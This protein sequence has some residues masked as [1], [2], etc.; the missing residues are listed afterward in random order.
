[1]SAVFYH[2]EEQ[3]RL[4]EAAKAKHALDVDGPIVTPILPFSGFTLAEDYHQKYRLR[5]EDDL[6]A[7]FE[8]IYPRWDDVVDST[9]AARVNSF[10]SGYGSL[11]QLEKEIESYGLSQGGRDRL[12]RHVKARAAR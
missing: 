7:E 12:L 1:M 3:K 5:G 10:L 11:E 4:A 9:A 8:A 2:D 6:V